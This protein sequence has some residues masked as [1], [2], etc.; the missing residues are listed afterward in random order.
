MQPAVE[1]SLEQAVAPPPSL[2][3][4]MLDL[5]EESMTAGPDSKPHPQPFSQRRSMFSASDGKV[6]CSC[7][8]VTVIIMIQKMQGVDD[9]RG[10]A[11]EELHSEEQV[12]PGTVSEMKEFADFASSTAC[13]HLNCFLPEVKVHLPTKHFLETLYNRQVYTVTLTSY[14]L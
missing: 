2:Q 1:R 9:K 6:G 7:C 5:L 10:V 11:G 4:D 13:Y 3:A 12:L 14:D 8:H